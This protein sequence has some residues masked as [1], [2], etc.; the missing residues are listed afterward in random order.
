MTLPLPAA[1][2]PASGAA[3]DHRAKVGLFSATSLVVGSMIGSGIY[4]VDSD[5]ARTTTGYAPSLAGLSI[6]LL[7]H[8]A[9]LRIRHEILPEQAGTVVLHHHHNRSLVESHIDG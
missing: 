9:H 1:A 8:L 7:L 5:I 6:Q 2:S 4:I 3:D